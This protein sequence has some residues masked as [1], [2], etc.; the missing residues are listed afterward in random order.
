MNFI[1]QLGHKN[2][3][4]KN[5][6]DPSSI[7]L[8]GSSPDI[9]KNELGHKIDSFSNVVRFN[10]VKVKGFEKNIG[11]KTTLLVMNSAAFDSS[12]KSYDK[13]FGK[14]HTNYDIKNKLNN[15]NILTYPIRQ[16]IKPKLTLQQKKE[17]FNIHESN[18][19]FVF[20]KPFTNGIKNE[21]LLSFIKNGTFKLPY[22]KND[23]IIPDLKYGNKKKLSLGITFI[24]IL[25]HN[26]I[27]PTITGFTLNNNIKKMDDY[28]R[29]RKSVSLNHDFVFEIDY[30]NQL[31]DEKL[32]FVLN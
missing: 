12:R 27:R 11:T 14:D 8:V 4:F 2:T 3:L 32:L 1:R 22:P 10:D 28:Y 13:I 29:T 23:N 16:V 21:D 20:W 9:L 26:G 7:I 25:V 31:I 5:L 30:L 18:D 6:T 19:I 17:L 24:L 15:I